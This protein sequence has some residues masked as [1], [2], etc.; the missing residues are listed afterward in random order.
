V[1]G[2]N[3]LGCALAACPG[4][5]QERF[6]VCGVF[7]TDPQAIG[8]PVNDLIVK[9]LRELNSVVRSE[10]VEIGVVA[11]SSEAA[12]YISDQLVLS[13]IKGIFNMSTAHIV[14]P[15]RISIVQIKLEDSIRELIYT[16]KPK[17][18]S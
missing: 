13:G 8:T 2:A 15:Q 17:L 14:A 11:V 4:F 16:I 10:H 6:I 12:Q 1:V 18:R 5:R 7:D 3:N 9:D